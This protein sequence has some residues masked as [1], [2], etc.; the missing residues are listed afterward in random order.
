MRG[1]LWCVRLL[2]L[3]IVS[4]I[5]LS[6]LAVSGAA[7]SSQPVGWNHSPSSFA[8]PSS[9]AYPAV[10]AYRDMRM[11]L[12]SRSFEKAEL[13]LQFSNQDAAAINTMIRRQEY[14][15]ARG[16]F[17]TYQH[18]F[19]RCIAWL[20]T[21]SDM[22]NN[23]SYLLSR[24]KSDHLAQQSA[25]AEAVE[26][27]PDWALEGVGETRTHVAQEILHAIEILEG[28]D[29]AASYARLIVSAYPELA[30]PREPGGTAE[31]PS[32][33]SQLTQ[34][35]PSTAVAAQSSP[36]P[37]DEQRSNGGPTIEKLVLADERIDSGE[38]TIVSCVLASAD[39]DQGNLRYAWWCSRG[40]LVT[41]GPEATWFAPDRD[42]TYEISVTVT[43]P[44]GKN[45]TRSIQVRVGNIGDGLSATEFEVKGHGDPDGSNSTGEDPAPV[46][47][48][49]TAVIPEIVSLTATAEHHYLD[50][51]L[52]GNYAILVS[53]DAEVHCEVVDSTGLSFEWT[54]T[55]DGELS[56]SGD[57]IRM[58]APSRPG[59]VTVSVTVSNAE[60][61]EDTR[62]LTFY[63][64]SCTY[65][66]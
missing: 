43:D 49:Y 42:G 61:E 53:R 52:G 35:V 23:V 14:V 56:G 37:P 20:L 18:T 41:N 59:Y 46:E 48:V 12:A 7:P 19:D 3:I 34:Q 60:G 13:L 30:V 38:S 45:D 27:L 22:G 54:V 28:G 9:P 8:L 25:L 15:T 10:V 2:L 62:S 5:V 51:N 4:G 11:S 50:Q 40:S 57:T 64:T 36:P 55:G 65:C 32:V 33:E 24:V 39:E 31:E 66:F 58:T 17:I 16:H 63:V 44:D 6:P 21:S 47:D 26:M 29:A 1:R